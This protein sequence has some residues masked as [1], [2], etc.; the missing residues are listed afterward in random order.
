MFR[1]VTRAVRAL[2]IAQ[3][4]TGSGSMRR[5]TRLTKAFSR[6]VENHAAVASLHAMY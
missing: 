5:F 1:S 3:G 2:Y 6:K 4:N